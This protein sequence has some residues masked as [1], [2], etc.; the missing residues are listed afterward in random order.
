[1]ALRTSFLTK[2][3]IE[4]K[5]NALYEA[6]AEAAIAQQ[7]GSGRRQVTAAQ[8]SQIKNSIIYWEARWSALVNK[9]SVIASPVR[10]R[11]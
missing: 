9:G 7:R 10:F 8:I 3:K 1:M 4:E 11:G 5:L 6:E 2:E